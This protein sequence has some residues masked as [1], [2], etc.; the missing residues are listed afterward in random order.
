MNDVQPRLIAGYSVALSGDSLEAAC[1]L[2]KAFAM[3]EASTRPVDFTIHVTAA[4]SLRRPDRTPDAVVQ[5]VERWSDGDA[6]VVVTD[7]RHT[8]TVDRTHAVLDPG[9]DGGLGVHTLLLPVLT[10]LLGMRGHCVVHAGVVVDADGTA[11]LVL[12]GSG[13][14]KSSLIAAALLGGQPV[15]GDDIAVLR[16]EP[17]GGLDVSGVPLPLALPGD[18]GSDERFGPPIDGDARGR[19]GAID[20]VR[21]DTAWHR[22]RGAVLVGHSTDPDGEIVPAKQRDVLLMLLASSLDGLSVGPARTVFPYAAALAAL[23]AWRLGHAPSPERRLAAA[24]H[25]LTAIA[26]S[27]FND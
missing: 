16:L 21:L 24:A 1:L 25:W 2:D 8:A 20:G 27:P 22:V 10:L 9:S 14:G 18:V 3:A 23:P 17:D 19:R 26:Q 5:H 13:M 7:A 11:V 4:G 15:A 6:H 12:G